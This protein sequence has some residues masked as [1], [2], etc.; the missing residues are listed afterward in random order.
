MVDKTFLKDPHAV[1]DYMFDWKSE[2]WLGVA[3][4][5]TARAVTVETGLTKDS[6]SEAGGIVTVWLSGGTA[7]Q[8]Y[9]VACKIDTSDSRTDERTIQVKVEER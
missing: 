9:T 1:L 6:D 7:G 2:N 3:E 8:S 5:I 4:T